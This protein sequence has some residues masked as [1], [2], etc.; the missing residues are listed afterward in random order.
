MP[1]EEGVK[2]T[3]D[4]CGKSEFVSYKPLT[5]KYGN[6]AKENDWK[7]IDRDIWLCPGCS[8]KFMAGLVAFLNPDD[9][10]NL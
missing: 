4:R 7:Q 1:R 10:L 6:E 2:Y 5:S 8:K 9:P 3:C